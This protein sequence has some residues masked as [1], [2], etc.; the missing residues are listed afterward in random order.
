M[1]TANLTAQRLREV[2]HYDPNSGVF[3]RLVAYRNRYSGRSGVGGRQRSGHIRI[4]VDGK[5]HFAHRLAWLFVNG[6]WPSGDLDHIDGDPANNRIA[7]LRLV[8]H[9]ANMQNFR[10]PTARSTTRLLGVSWCKINKKWKACISI[11]GR[12]KHLGL[13]DLP[14]AAHA[15]YVSA[16]RIHHDGCTI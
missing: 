6:D 12:T 8:T 4:C 3:A 1:A 7:N 14:E 13:F 11:G 16:K 15:A 5:K 2:L 10:R 9:E